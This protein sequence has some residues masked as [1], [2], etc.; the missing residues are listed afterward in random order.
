MTVSAPESITIDGRQGSVIY[1]DDKFAVVDK[2]RA[3]LAKVV[4][5]DGSVGF[6]RIS[7]D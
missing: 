5:E 2:S 1:L 4:F 6:Y 3:T 7:R